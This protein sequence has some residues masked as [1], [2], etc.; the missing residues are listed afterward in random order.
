MRAV[1]VRAHG[2]LQALES[3]EVP[4]PQPGHGEVRVGVR[5]C[6]VNHLDIWVRRGVPGHHFP[7]P[8]IPGNDVAGVVEALGPGVDDLALGDAVVVAPGIGCSHC[9]TCLRG[10]DHHC[11]AYVIVGEHRDGGYADSLVVPRRNVLPLPAQLDFIGAAALGTAFLTAWQML[12]GRARVAAGEWV[13]VQ[14]AGSGVGTAA[15]QIA[16]LWGARVLAVASSAAK[17]A[18][19]LQLGA[20]V[21]IDASRENVVQV[22]KA[23]TQGAGAEVVLD[24]VGQD[25]WATSLRCLSWQG[26]LVVCGATTG[27]TV[28]LDLRHLFFKSQSILGSTL[29][30]LEDFAQVLAHASRGSLQPVIDRVLP[31]HRVGEAHAALEA[32]QVFGKIVLADGARAVP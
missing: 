17:V 21:G 13:L 3:Q 14:A 23:H 9:L 30:S 24:H 8:L 27:A 32:R 5:A 19:A 6:G 31:R 4:T 20:S 22:V 7:L 2:G 10:N 29:G 1:V 25:S 11:R 28:Q 15:V 26:R 12:V 16:R 18:R